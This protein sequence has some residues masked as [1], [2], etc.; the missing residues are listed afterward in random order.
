[1]N[2]LLNK[3]I[4]TKLLWA[5]VLLNVFFVIYYC[6]LIYY[7]RLSQDDYDFLH[8]LK[9]QSIFDF[10]KTVYFEHQGRFVSFFIQGIKY[11]L[12]EKTGTFAFVPISVFVI[13]VLSLYYFLSKIFTAF[14]MKKLFLISLLFIN[15]FLIINFEFSSFL[16]IAACSSI[17]LAAPLLLIV[18]V[19]Y[20]NKKISWLYAIV[21]SI[22]IGGSSEAFSPLILFILFAT[23]FGMLFFRKEKSVKDVISSCVF[24]KLILVFCIISVCFLIVYIAPGNA[25]RLG[26]YQQPDT[27]MQFLFITIKNVIKFSYLSFFKLPYILFMCFLSFVMGLKL[28]KQFNIP[29]Q[30]FVYSLIVLLG[31]IWLSTFPA[32]YA[33]SGFGF[34]RI[35]APIVFW[36]LL[37]GCFISFYFGNVI[38]KEKLNANVQTKLSNLLLICIVFVSTIQIVNILHDTPL[39]RN[40][41]LADKQRIADFLEQKVLGRTEPMYF[42]ALP[43][44]ETEN[45]KSFLFYERLKN[46][47]IPNVYYSKTALYYSNDIDVEIVPNTFIGYSNLMMMQYY[48]LPFPIYLKKESVITDKNE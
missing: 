42:D 26:T 7:S 23:A 31:V 22:I 41:Y 6:I 19:F 3:K 4:E 48:D 14:S 30:Y 8:I 44:T 38:Y 46:V 28:E 12:I 15:I 9:K 18:V 10:V 43:S 35:Y 16:W 20:N 2:T 11:S 27:L 13:S 32:A 24:K 5:L 25:N 40:Y 29:I 1:M 37:Y 36:L 17:G 45:I 47:Q 39:A 34:Q 21:I 33:M